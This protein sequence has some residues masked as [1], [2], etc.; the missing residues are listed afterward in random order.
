[1]SGFCH[2]KCIF[3]GKEPLLEK[4]DAGTAA[5]K[6]LSID[7]KLLA[8]VLIGIILVL[9]SC[10]LFIAGVSVGRLSVSKNVV[11]VDVAKSRFETDSNGSSERED[12]RVTARRST[13]R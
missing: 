3:G 11:I 9:S 12:S 10:L 4:C 2:L 1:M 8:L 13:R 5:A 7:D 6:A